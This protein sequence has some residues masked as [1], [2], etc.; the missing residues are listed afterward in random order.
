[1][2]LKEECREILSAHAALYVVPTPIGNLRD[3]TL[4]ALDVLG[5]ADLVL[6]EDTRRTRKLFARYGI[7]RPLVSCERFS[8]ARRIDYVLSRLEEGSRVALVS[9]A[10]TPTVSDPGSR[11][12][13]QVRNAGFPVVVLPGPSAV[14]TA[15]AASGI[16][17]PFRFMG[18][19]PRKKAEL[20][21]FIAG[22]LSSIESTVFYES[23]RRTAATLGVLAARDSGRYV[24]VGREITKIHEEYIA[25][26][27]IHVLQRLSRVEVKGEVT[28]VVEGSSHGQA[29]TS[30]SVDTAARRLVR[31]GVPVREV[32][33]VLS[34]LMG[35]PR[36]DIYRAVLAIRAEERS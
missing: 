26:C 11:L 25:G 29:S 1:M 14:V 20:D 21:A 13:R 3:V 9:D 31:L 2:G 8:E 10:G 18:F 15:F 36:N 28:V 16:E 27:A 32:S 12:V 19:A 33:A 17:G 5:Q 22:I 30:K 7:S 6:C 23:P 34:E 35:I 4:R 24:C